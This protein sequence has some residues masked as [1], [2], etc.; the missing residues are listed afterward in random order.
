MPSTGH[1]S[2]VPDVPAEETKVVRVLA[3]KQRDHAGDGHDDEQR[4]THRRDAYLGA[5][6]VTA[7]EH[8]TFG[9]HVSFR[10]SVLL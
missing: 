2:S 8:T 5:A 6:A 9:A 1:E 7:S 4:R 3:G 10:G